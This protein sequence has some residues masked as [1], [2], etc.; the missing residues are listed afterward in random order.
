MSY[1]SGILL[2]ISLPVTV[3]PMGIAMTRNIHVKS[4]DDITA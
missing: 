2:K 4:I 3:I 1:V